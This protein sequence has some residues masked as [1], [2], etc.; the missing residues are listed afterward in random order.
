M[1]FNNSILTKSAIFALVISS[2]AC[3]RIT[4]GEVGVR[5]NAS[6]EV[7]QEELLP[8][9]WNQTIIGNVLTFPVKD[10]VIEVNDKRYTTSDNATLQDFDITVVYSINPSSASELYTKKSRA[11]HRFEHDT[12]DTYLM[13]NYVNTLVN[14]AAYKVIRN[15]GNLEAGDN[16]QKIESD[17][18]VVIEEQLKLE[19]LDIALQITAVQIRSIVPNAEIQN[20]ATALVRSQNELK[21]KDNEVKIAEKESERMKALAANSSQSVLYMEA[22]AKMKIAEAIANGKVQTII[23]PSNMTSLMLN[24]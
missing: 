22:Q 19:K 16:R 13:Y 24:R 17:I 21:I 11:F 4:T 3:T 9:S 18:R 5:V 1:T 12:W 20:A 14:N 10:V 15:Y 6:L 7:Q 23:V 8:G 2:A